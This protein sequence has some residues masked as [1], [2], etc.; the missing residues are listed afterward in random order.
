MQQSVE[1]A[2]QRLVMHTEGVKLNAANQVLTRGCERLGYQ[3]E[4][5]AQE[6]WEPESPDNGG[7]CTLGWKHGAR[8]GMHGSALVDAARTGNLVFLD[9]CRAHEILRD[10]LGRA[11][12]VRATVRSGP[13]SRQVI[14][15]GRCVVVAGGSLQTPQLLRRSGLKNKHI[16]RHLHLH[17]AMLIW[18]RFKEDIRHFEGAPMTTVSRVLWRTRMA[19]ATAPRPGS[20][21]S[22]P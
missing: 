4:V 3:S 19:V 1:Q 7:W 13:N 15:R 2:R 16:G 5:A 20:P 18:G 22:T 10:S 8:Q 6:G 9:G 12:A 17:P 11:C 14:V 21:T